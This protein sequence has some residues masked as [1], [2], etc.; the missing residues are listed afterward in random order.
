MKKNKPETG[1]YT[2]TKFIGRLAPFTLAHKEIIDRGLE[3]SEYVGLDL[4]TCFQPRME[5]TPFTAEERMEMVLGAFTPAQQKRL[6]ITPIMDSPYNNTV[7]Q[8]SIQ[9]STLDAYE[10]IGAESNP[11]V[12]L[13][14]NEKDARGN[15]FFLDMFPQWGSIGVETLYGNL[16]ATT[17]RNDL[18]TQRKWTGELN[19]LIPASTADALVKFSKASDFGDL[20]AEVDYY[21]EYRGAHE[22]AAELIRQKLGYKTDIKH[23]TVDALVVCAGHVLLIE[24]KNLPG[25]G[26]MALPGGFLDTGEWLSDAFIRELREETKIKVPTPVLRGSLKGHMRADY[27]HRSARGRVISDVY[28]LQI[29]LVNGEFPSV[30]GRSDAKVARWIPIAEITPSNMFEDHYFVIEHLLAKLGK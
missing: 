4:G 1:K 11:T 8:T 25:R 6:I 21:R 20:L 19:H 13:I 27:P 28:L 26:L 14:G 10:K 24:R 29:D 7:W 2:L 30:K 22:E 15:H 3:C 16:S 5:R 12:A 9:Q 23:M 17:L 18:F